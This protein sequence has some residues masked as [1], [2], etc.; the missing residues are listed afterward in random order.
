[1]SDFVQFPEDVYARAGNAFAAFDPNMTDFT[2]PNA[3]AL[4]WFAQLAYEV[5]TSGASGTL[6]KISRIAAL[7]QFQ[8]VSTFRGSKTEFGTNYDTTGLLGIRSNAVLLA[9]AG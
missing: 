9:F 4:M 6:D 1:M 3:R 8:S 2:I 7:W 5:D